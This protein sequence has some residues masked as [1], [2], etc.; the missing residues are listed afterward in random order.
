MP[1]S[2]KLGKMKLSV[3]SIRDPRVA[4]RSVVWALAAL[5]VLAAVV[6]FHPF[7]GSGDDLRRDEAALRQQLVELEKRVQ[8]AKGLVGK[9]ELAHKEGDRFLEKYVMDARTFS[10]QLGEELNRTA[11]EAGIRPMQRTTQLQAIEG[12]DALSMVTV[13]A[14]YE[15][16]YAGIKKFV[17]LIDKSPRFLIIDTM[18]VASPQ[19]QSGQLVNVNLKLDAFVRGA[20]GAAL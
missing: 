13:I 1:K 4:M 14:G 3:P 19:T 5:N 9:V 7:G 6:A 2:L 15:G 11:K 17:E 12:S 16:T 8:T 20:P 18:A 10:S